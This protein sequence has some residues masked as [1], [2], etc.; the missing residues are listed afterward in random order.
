MKK[1]SK[2][3]HLSTET[4][5]TLDLS[6]AVAGLADISNDCQETLKNLVCQTMP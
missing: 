6:T 3:L 4:L 2:K 5:K 1:K